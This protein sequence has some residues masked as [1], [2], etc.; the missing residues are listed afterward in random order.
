MSGPLDDMDETSGTLV[1]SETA[2][3]SGK[4]TDLDI[5]LEL[6]SKARAENM[7]CCNI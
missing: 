7:R 4:M 6:F 3:E 5:S 1:D 2:Q